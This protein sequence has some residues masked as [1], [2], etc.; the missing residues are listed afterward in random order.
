MSDISNR[1][2]VIDSRDVIAKIEEM[3]EEIFDMIDGMEIDGIDDADDLINHVAK[4]IDHSEDCSTCDMIITAL[5]YNGKTSDDLDEA[6]DELKP[7][8]DLAGEASDYA[9]DWDHGETMIRGTY[10]KEY[11]QQ[12][13]DDIGAIDS[14]A[15]WPM[16]CID[17]DQAANELKQDYTE[18][19][20]NGISYFIR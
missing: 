18:V 2:D 4:K 8:A 5:V 19:D 20:F 11:A 6:I 1:D 13:A 16:N 14:S 7:L 3:K 15:T 10:F 9:E 12:L 17:W